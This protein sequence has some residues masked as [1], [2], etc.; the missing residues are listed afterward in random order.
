MPGEV[1]IGFFGSN[2]A[3]IQKKNPNGAPTIT[4]QRSEYT[5]L[6]GRKGE[7]L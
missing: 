2:A 6:L 1:T 4:P 7:A 3:L 5:L